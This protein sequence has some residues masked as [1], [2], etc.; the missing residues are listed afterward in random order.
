MPNK[1]ETAS[2]TESSLNDFSILI[3]EDDD[4]QR[5][6]LARLVKKYGANAVVEAT[7]GVEALE[8]VGQREDSFDLILSDLDMPNMDGLEFI[9]ALGERRTTSALAITSAWDETFLS[10]VHTMCTAYGIE[11][12]GVLKKPITAAGIAH[13]LER[14]Q[15]IINQ[16][17]RRASGTLPSF[18]LQEI[19]DGVDNGEFEPFF[20]P[21]LDLETGKIVS[22]EALARWRHP[23]HGV[24]APFAFIDTL[25]SAGKIDALTFVMIDHAAR[26]CRSWQQAGLD[27]GISVNLSLASLTDTNL[28]ERIYQL[29]KKAGLKPECMTL[30]I[31]E[32]AAMTEMAP[33]LENL[34]RLRMRGFGLSIDDYGTGFA[35][36]QQLARI[37]FTELKIDRSFVSAMRDKREALAIVESSIDIARRLGITAVAEGVESQEE[38]HVLQEAGCKQA[39]GYLISKP[40]E[41]VEFV[42]FC[43]RELT[44]I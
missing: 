43:R 42:A 4:F 25:E 12:L 7:D 28:A 26:A 6:L 30:E 39:Q 19:M 17:R 3:V 13:L 40:V 36:M 32:T 16:P 20:Q 29:V 37:A 44:C 27:I 1:L 5:H 33:A 10:S 23:I 21:K 38:L 31:T 34:A 35:S 11:P 15:E 14:A 41:Q 18:T 2:L 9:R 24:V 22:A 8:I